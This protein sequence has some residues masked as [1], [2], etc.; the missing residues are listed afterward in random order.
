MCDG[1]GVAVFLA[2]VFDT[3]K[4]KGQSV[5]PHLLKLSFF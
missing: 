3:P 4:A 2:N 1:Y 5:M